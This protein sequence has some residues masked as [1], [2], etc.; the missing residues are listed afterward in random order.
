MDNTIRYKRKYYLLTN[1]LPSPALRTE[2]LLRVLV[3]SVVLDLLLPLD[4]TARFPY[5]LGREVSLL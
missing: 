3:C 4:F 5:Q 1:Y 2:N